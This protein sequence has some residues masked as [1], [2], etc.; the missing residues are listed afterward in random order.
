MFFVYRYN[1]NLAQKIKSQAVIAAA[2]DNLSDALVSVGTVIGIVG[3]QLNLPW[4]DPLTAVIVG[5]IICKTAWD[6]FREAT[7]HL[8]DAFDEDLLS[9]YKDVALKVDG[10]EE[11]KNIKARNYGSN[12]VIDI[13][14]LV[15][16]ELKF[17][18]AHD[19]ATQVELE[20]KK[21]PDVYEVHVHYEPNRL[22]YNS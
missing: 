2:K 4:L 7:H 1:R 12:A 6:I 11:V 17:E 5:L 19:V 10:V 3:S 15:G 16:A 18:Q 20:L 14:L 21:I 9:G 8:S 13:T 22:S